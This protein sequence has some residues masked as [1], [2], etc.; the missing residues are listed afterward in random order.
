MS[1][2]CIEDKNEI[3]IHINAFWKEKFSIQV[4]K[5]DVSKAET[6]NIGTKLANKL[7]SFIK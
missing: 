2:Q 6:L 3:E 5:M 1:N 7:D 4:R